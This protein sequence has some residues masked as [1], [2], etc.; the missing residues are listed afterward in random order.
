M[1]FPERLEAG[2]QSG[3]PVLINASEEDVVQRVME[4][5][6]GAGV[7]YGYDATRSGTAI[8]TLM[9]MAAQSGKILLVGSIP[10]IVEIP[11]FD[12]L[13]TKELS[14]IGVLQPRSPMIAHPYYPWTQERNRAE[15]LDL[16]ARQ[17]IRVDHLITHR[18]AP[19]DAAG[20]LRH[21]CARRFGL[22][23]RGFCVVRTSA[24]S[25]WQSTIGR[26]NR[27]AGR[28]PVRVP[29]YRHCL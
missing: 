16:L 5:T 22:A 19:E 29:A 25:L 23:G 21:D 15:I 7:T 24:R 11:L 28:R 17:A 8:R 18:M 12:P 14:I 26:D 3:T 10:R 2:V 1:C 6:D 13:Q 9:D 4:A 20:D 27:M